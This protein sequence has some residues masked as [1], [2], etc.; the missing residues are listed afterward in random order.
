MQETGA[1]EQL[2]KEY[3]MNHSIIIRPATTDRVKHEDSFT[4]GGW[5]HLA[6]GALILVGDNHGDY[7]RSLIA[8]ASNLL[9]SI[10]PQKVEE[11]AELQHPGTW[12]AGDRIVDHE[13]DVHT[14]RADGNWEFFDRHS[15]RPVICWEDGF[16]DQEVGAKRSSI[17][18]LVPRTNAEAV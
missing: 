3:D 10:E 2:T 12:L 18:H 17:T 14:R 13:G 4:D 16:V 11:P 15:R 8:A 9:S 6:P 5:L 1:T 7:L